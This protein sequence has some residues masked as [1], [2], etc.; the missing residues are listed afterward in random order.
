MLHK[1][2]SDLQIQLVGTESKSMRAEAFTNAFDAKNDWGT[3]CDL[4]HVAQP[5]DL[6]SL[7]KGDNLDLF[8]IKQA[9][10]EAVLQS[11]A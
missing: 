4:V 10:A 11:K 6:D 3:V 9:P 5:C 8:I 7:Q 2:L 1:Q